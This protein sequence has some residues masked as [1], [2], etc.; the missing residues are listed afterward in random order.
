MAYF[1]YRNF[2]GEFWNALIERNELYFSSPDQ[3]NDPFDCRIASNALDLPRE[4]QRIRVLEEM[5]D[6]ILG[7]LTSDNHVSIVESVLNGLPRTD[8]GEA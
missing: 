6:H 1:K 7:S 2:Q 3:L 5:P 4:K 8:K